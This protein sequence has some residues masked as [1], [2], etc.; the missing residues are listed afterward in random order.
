MKA[1]FRFF[2]T[3]RVRYAE[4]DGQGIVFNAHYLTYADVAVVE[5]FRFL[6]LDCAEM[7]REDLMDIALVKSTLNFKSSAGF[8]DILE[9]GARVSHLGNSSFTMD[10]EVF[11]PSQDEPIVGVESVYVNYNAATRS[12]APLPDLFI[13]AVRKVDRL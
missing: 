9:I 4:I 10:F 13:E 6:G 12:S 5:Y 11:K 2:H 7:A 3:L 1:D 8:D